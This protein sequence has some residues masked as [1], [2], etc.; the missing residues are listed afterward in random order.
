MSV[1]YKVSFVVTQLFNTL[2]LLG[3]FFHFFLSSTHIFLLNFTFSTHNLSK[4][5]KS[6]VFL[7]CPI[8]VWL[9]RIGKSSTIECVKETDLRCLQIKLMTWYSQWSILKPTNTFTSCRKDV[10]YL[11]TFILTLLFTLSTV[12]YL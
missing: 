11:V 2:Y 7:K 9:R 10:L 5:I 3:F 8:A 12:F 4:V 1:I 6:L